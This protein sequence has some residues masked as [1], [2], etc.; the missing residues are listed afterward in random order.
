MT[1][2][3]RRTF[4]AA[5]RL[6]NSLGDYPEAVRRLAQAH[7]LPLIDLNASTKVMY[8]AWGPDQATNAFVH[9]PANTYPDQV[10]ELKDETHF[11]NFGAYEIARLVVEGIRS[12]VPGLASH[13]AGDAAPFDPA[14]PDSF[15]AFHLA[16]S[17]N[18]R[19]Q[20]VPA[21]AK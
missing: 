1:S 15:A 2:M 18:P 16:V 8:E 11:R 19:A 5:G 14:H 12:G 10:K 7:G 3:N 13:L 20:D 6:T 21:Q 17:P 4:D 9:F